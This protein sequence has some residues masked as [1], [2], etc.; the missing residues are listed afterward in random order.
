MCDCGPIVFRKEYKCY[1]CD[2]A[3]AAQIDIHSDDEAYCRPCAVA[4]FGADVVAEME[5]VK[6]AV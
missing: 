4:I 5:E 6:D 3:P 1:L 2:K